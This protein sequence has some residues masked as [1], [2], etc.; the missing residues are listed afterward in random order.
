[1]FWATYKATTRRS[2]VFSGASGQKDFNA[3][4]FE[5]IGKHL[6]GNWERAFQ[7]RLPAALESFAR[8]GKQIIKAFHDDV[9]AGVQQNLTQ[10][11]TGLNMLNQ[12][13][14]VYTAAMEA[15]PAALR[16]AI[17]ER[18][19]DANREFTPVIQQAMQ[20]AYD[21]CTAERGMYPP[22]PYHGDKKPSVLTKPGP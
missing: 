15:A 19:R 18:Q 8:A 17:T 16:T 9:V 14:R 3:E 20:H 12:Q 2:G 13:I 5:P 11:P 7:R 21:V 22:E 6:A 10:N 1:L 4:L